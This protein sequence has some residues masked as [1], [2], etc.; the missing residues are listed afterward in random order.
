MA[1]QLS[2][3]APT[4]NPKAS[5]NFSLKPKKFISSQFVQA[6]PP[7]ALPAP[8]DPAV[9]AAASDCGYGASA[10]CLGI[11]PVNEWFALQ[12]FAINRF[13]GVA[14]LVTAPVAGSWKLASF[15]KFIEKSEKS[16][17]AHILGSVYCR[18]AAEQ[19]QSSCGFA[20]KRFWH[21]GL[22]KHPAVNLA[23][24]NPVNASQNPDF[25]YENSNGD[26]F[27]IEAKGSLGKKDYSEL[28]EGLE[29]ASKFQAISFIEP[30]A[31]NVVS[32]ALAGFACSGTYFDMHSNELQVEHVDPPSDPIFGSDSQEPGRF[33]IPEFADL[34][35]FH[36]AVLEFGE[37]DQEAARREISAVWRKWHGGGNVLVGISE[38]HLTMRAELDWAI[39]ALSLVVPVLNR[40]AHD[41]R[42]ASDLGHSIGRLASQVRVKEAASLNAN[43]P[44]A[45]AWAAFADVLDSHRKP[46]EQVGW[47]SVLVSLWTR[48]ILKA[49]LNQSH[50]EESGS[51]G[52][53][54][55]SLTSVTSALRESVTLDKVLSGG[56]NQTTYATTHGLIFALQK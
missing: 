43:S 30:A 25:V 11:V 23:G 33:L 53:L 14:S 7:I 44:E 55:G 39:R 56:R 15:A 13:L 34:V 50:V 51:I 36:Q 29:Q 5:L 22:A 10:A 8:L 2:F 12:A 48:P 27:A 3:W 18:Y 4:V 47:K 9:I 31:G 37:Q 24:L 1:S 32:A 28:K 54:W 16:P 46:N 21:F 35:R 45:R 52:N 20:L 6:S 38:P 19:W 42:A 17:A 41:D 40:A 49:F 26:W